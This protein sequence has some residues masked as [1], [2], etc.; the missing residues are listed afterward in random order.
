[1]RRS[2]IRLLITAAFVVFT[3]TAYAEWDEVLDGMKEKAQ[4]GLINTLTGWAEL[5][6]QIVKGYD[7]GFMGEEGNKLFGVVFGGIKGIAYGAGRTFSGV[8]DLAGFWA[9]SPIDN[10]RI[11]LP[12]EAEYAWEEGEIYDMSNPNF[13]EATIRPMTNKF[14]RGAGNTIFG[15]VEIPNQIKEGI[16]EGS[17]DLGIP[18][19]LW[20]WLSRE[21]SGICDLVTIP[22][23]NPEDTI[24]V[25]FDEK[26]AWETFPEG[27]R[28]E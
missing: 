13:I 24:G 1:M 25:T 12:L 21:F 20:F 18:K 22:F 2:L 5:P 26:M 8:A 23:A 16:S 4:R 27:K 9:A 14:F 6:Y 10:E 15:F 17:W 3:T 28:R 19:G 7:E 11:G